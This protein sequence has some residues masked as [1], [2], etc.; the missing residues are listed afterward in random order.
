MNPA[1]TL[2]TAPPAT[3]AL[4]IINPDPKADPTPEMSFGMFKAKTA[5]DSG[6]YKQAQEFFA[7]ALSKEEALPKPRWRQ[8]AYIRYGLSRTLRKMG[9]HEAASKH[10]EA[11][12]VIWL[13]HLGPHHPNIADGYTQLAHESSRRGDFAARQKHLLAALPI[14]LQH[15]GPT[16]NPVLTAYGELGASYSDI[17]NFKRAFAYFQTQLGIVLVL[18]GAE[19]VG[20]PLVYNNLAQALAKQGEH[21]K[22]MEFMEKSMALGIKIYGE[23]HLQMSLI[24]CN[25]AKLCIQRPEPDLKEANALLARAEAI[26]KTDDPTGKQFGNHR[27]NFLRVCGNLLLA[28]K[29]YQ[30]ALRM[31]EEHM[32]EILKLG[33]ATNHPNLARTQYLM[34]EARQGLGQVAE[35]KRLFHRAHAIQIRTLL[36]THPHLLQSKAVLAKM[37]E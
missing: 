11:V 15:F 7:E 20:I 2:T 21:R 1:K 9:R 13:R 32:A 36:P 29:Q 27:S 23:Q 37:G 26:L 8:V 6:R 28:E 17:G 18:Q 24:F 30:K 16:S 22:A 5:Y 14:W 3:L 10:L 31:H 35:A 33:I 12:L 34:G 19:G 4:P 25:T